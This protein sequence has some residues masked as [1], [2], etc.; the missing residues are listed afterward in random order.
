[1]KIKRYFQYVKESK[2]LVNEE[3]AME[4]E[5]PQIQMEEEMPEMPGDE[6]RP[7]VIDEEEMEEEGSE[8]F[9]KKMLAELAE[10]LDCELHD[11]HID[12]NGKKINFYSETESFHV[13]RKKFKT[14]EEVVA[15]LSN[16]VPSNTEQ[17]GESKSY[18]TTRKFENHKRK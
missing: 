2:N 8:Y 6:V 12:C 11:N 14:A 15:Y 3:I 9:G 10:M 17:L 4:Q 1:M 13:D 7:D 16:E 18:R 5:V